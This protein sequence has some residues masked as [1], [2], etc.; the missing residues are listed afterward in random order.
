MEAVERH[1]VLRGCL[2]S[3]WRL[4][5]CNPF[6]K[7]GYDPVERLSDFALEKIRRSERSENPCILTERQNA[8]VLR[9]A[10]DE[11]GELDRLQPN[12]AR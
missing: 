8:S 11:T 7:G 1:G 4:L 10:Q 12:C 6:S 2:M 5:R 3:A 9:C